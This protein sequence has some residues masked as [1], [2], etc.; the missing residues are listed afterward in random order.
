M[1]TVLL[2]S[3]LNS[4][5]DER[6]VS[7]DGEGKDKEAVSWRIQRQADRTGIPSRQCTN[8]TQEETRYWG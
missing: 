3:L 2:S 6:V 5:R 8:T 7:K 1:C 4:S